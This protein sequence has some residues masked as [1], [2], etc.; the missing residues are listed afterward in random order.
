MSE[1]IVDNYK[2]FLGYT[3]C[4]N[5]TSI[6]FLEPTDEYSKDGFRYYI[7]PACGQEISFNNYD[8][9]KRIVDA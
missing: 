4:K 6:L 2:A 8:L 5:C 7:C 1:I 3:R 9:Y